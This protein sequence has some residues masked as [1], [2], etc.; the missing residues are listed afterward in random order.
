[1]AAAV[2]AQAEL[3][4]IARQVN[5]QAVEA[6]QQLGVLLFEQPAVSDVQMRTKHPQRL[7]LLIANQHLTTV[8]HPYPVAGLVA[9][10]E[11]GLV[12]RL[13]PGKMLLH[14]LEGQPQV[15]FVGQACP[16]ID[17]RGLQFGEGVAHDLRPGLVEAGLAGLHVP[18]PGADAGALQQKFRHTIFGKAC[19]G[20]A[21][22][23]G[24]GQTRST[25]VQIE[26]SLASPGGHLGSVGVCYLCEWER[27]LPANPTCRSEPCSR[28]ACAKTNSR[29]G[30]APTGGARSYSCASCACA[31]V[32]PCA[33]AS[34][35]Q[36][37]ASSRSCVTPSPAR[38]SRP[39]T[40]CA[41]ACPCS[42]AC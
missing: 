32:W 35:S 13:L 17:C 6:V 28:S 24:D 8:Q 5:E 30:P 36:R 15:F 26:A 12:L 20:I 27:A 19:S 29:A 16:C 11:L 41:L 3:V 9:H 39:S 22:H 2:R 31:S 4:E 18:D 33:A 14:G 10:A 42:A 25:E 23:G 7:A 21:A 40:A 37:L 38:Y 1:M 34:A